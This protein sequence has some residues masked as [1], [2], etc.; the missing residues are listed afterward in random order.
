KIW[1]L[2]NAI[3]T[4]QGR[5]RDMVQFADYIYSVPF[6]TIAKDWLGRNNGEWEF[7]STDGRTVDRQKFEEFKTIY[8]QLEGWD[9]ATG[10]PSRKTLESLGLSYVADELEQNGK[11][12]SS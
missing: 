4:L 12:G 5:H 11:S 10:Y 9:T 6:K 2:D 8:Y 1:N 7:I 3:W